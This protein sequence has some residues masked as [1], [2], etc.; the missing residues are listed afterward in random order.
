MQREGLIQSSTVDGLLIA[1]YFSDPERTV[2]SKTA[3]VDPSD[4]KLMQSPTRRRAK[5]S[6]LA[7]RTNRTE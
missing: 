6:G 3:L 7:N 5:A 4:R 1:T 2:C